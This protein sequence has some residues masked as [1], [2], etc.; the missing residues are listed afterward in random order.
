MKRSQLSLLTKI[1]IKNI[2]VSY[3]ESQKKAESK[4]FIIKEICLETYEDIN[5]SY[6]SSVIRRIPQII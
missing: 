4:G 2:E 6:A 3:Q 5:E 1:E